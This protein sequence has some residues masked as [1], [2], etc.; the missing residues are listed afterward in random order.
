MPCSAKYLFLLAFP[1]V[2]R[3]CPV[4]RGHSGK[5]PGVVPMPVLVGVGEVISIVTAF[6]SKKE[7]TI[8]NGR[9]R[10]LGGPGLSA[11]STEKKECG[12]EA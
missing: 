7:W 11:G 9:R 10:I 5:T 2:R 1:P 6:K 12:G 3:R 8:G 4:D